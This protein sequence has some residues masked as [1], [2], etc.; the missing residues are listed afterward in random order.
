MME[1]EQKK[2]K[3]SFRSRRIRWVFVVLKKKKIF[4]ELPAENE[5][6]EKK[7]ILKNVIFQSTIHYPCFAK[8]FIY[9]VI[10]RILCASRR[11][12]YWGIL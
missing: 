10:C 12:L 3:R 11:R 7:K 5:D 4:L 1:K 2:G 6:A 8:H 9:E